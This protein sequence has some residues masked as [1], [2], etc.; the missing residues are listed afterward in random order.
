VTA[1]M[2]EKT[3]A[4]PPPVVT[5]R[6]L[7]PGRLLTMVILAVL[8]AMLVRSLVTNPNFEWGVVRHY[9]FSGDILSGLWMT[10][11][12]TAASMAIGIALGTVLAVM[13]L[14][15]NPMITGASAG[16]VWLFRGTPVLVQIIFWFNLSSLYPRLSLSVP[17][18]PEIVG[19][20]ANSLI[21][22]MMAAILG[23]GL[24]EAAYMAE[25][26]RSGIASVDEGQ[27]D[28]AQ[29]LG[30]RHFQVMRLVVLPQAVKVAIP[31][32]GN[33]TIGMLK[34]TALVSVIA[35]PEL[36][37]SAQIIYSQSFQTIP[38]L[39]VASIWYLIVTTVLSVGQHYLERRFSWNSR[40]SATGRQPE[41]ATAGGRG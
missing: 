1:S 4:G 19:G 2:T 20:D 6:E 7:H 38:L 39:I 23:L 25:I 22:P 11:L 15:K 30:M 18:G 26:I 29:G 3:T 41:L 9:F 32:T 21:T 37:Y 40:T 14:S 17:F 13:R 33:E 8:A 24:N 12:L 35:M 5:S 31:P 10:L 34:H 16:Y 36:L 28:A 27:F